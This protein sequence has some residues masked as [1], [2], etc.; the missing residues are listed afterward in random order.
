[1]Q[2][3]TGTEEV[4]VVKFDVEMRENDETNEKEGKIIL[5]SRPTRKRNFPDR[6][7]DTEMLQRQVTVKKTVSIKKSVSKKK[8]AHTVVDGKSVLHY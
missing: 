1:M 8:S 3:F 5:E 2:C 7:V 6:Y 4:H